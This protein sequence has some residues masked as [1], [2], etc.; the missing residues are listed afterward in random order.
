M[1]GMT[2][3]RPVAQ[4]AGASFDVGSSEG[5]LA[6]TPVQCWFFEQRFARPDHFNQSVVLELQRELSPEA[7]EA[8]LRD[9][10]T[11]HPALRLR[12]EERNGSVLQRYSATADGPL[13]EHT[14]LADDG[15]FADALLQLADRAQQSLS[16]ADGPLLRALLIESASGALARAVKIDGRVDDIFTLQD[17][18]V[19]ELTEGLSLSLGG[20]EIEAIERTETASIAAYE[21]YARGMDLLFTPY[22]FLDLTP[23]GR[24]EDWEDSPPGWPQKPTYG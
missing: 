11:A 22:N 3:Q 13:L 16:L 12:F 5:E 1:A 19:F 24:Q 23:Y 2:L 9:I 8:A 14:P 10:M 20:S 21:A 17:R 6:L 18:V 4:R 7:L 15:A